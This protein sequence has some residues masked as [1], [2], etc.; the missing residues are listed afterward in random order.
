MNESYYCDNDHTFSFCFNP[1]ITIH[2]VGFETKGQSV[3]VVVSATKSSIEKVQS[4]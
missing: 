4:F 1:Q 3:G 2:D